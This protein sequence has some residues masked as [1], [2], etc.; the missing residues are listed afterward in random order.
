MGTVKESAVI[1]QL[2]IRRCAAP[3]RLAV[4]PGYEYRWSHPPAVASRLREKR[5]ARPNDGKGDDRLLGREVAAAA[6]LS[7][8][9][10]R[11]T[12]GR[13]RER[14]CMSPMD[15]RS[16][17]Y[18]SGYDPLINVNLPTASA[19]ASGAAVAAG[20]ATGVV[21]ATS[22]TTAAALAAGHAG[23]GSVYPQTLPQAY[24]HPLPQTLL[25]FQQQQYSLPATSQPQFQEQHHAQTPPPSRSP[26]VGA[27]PQVIS[28]TQQLLH[29][30]PRHSG[31]YGAAASLGQL[32]QQ[33]RSQSHPHSQPQ[34]QPRPQPQPQPQYGRGSQFGL[35][36]GV[37]AGAM[38]TSAA[39]M[40]PS[41][42]QHVPGETPAW[43]C[44]QA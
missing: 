4:C 39:M 23:P 37:P 40:Y 7:H 26:A 35:A 25:P 6:G 1:V 13:G 12:G 11:G 2:R 10:P 21:D 29:F 18:Q 20:T 36:Y 38:Q 9:A 27:R 34:A 3:A 24:T 5:L 33:P 15:V 17:D 19:S 31:L 44:Y 22:T 8:R 16:M 32:G 30:S 43:R 14:A 28:G 41:M 42:P